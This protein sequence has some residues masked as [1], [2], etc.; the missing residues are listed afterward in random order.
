LNFIPEIYNEKLEL[1]SR[2]DFEGKPK[3]TMDDFFLFF[4]K[5]KFKMTKIIKRNCEQMLMSILKYAAEDT[6]IDLL[7]KF[8]G[9]GDDKV[10]RE[11][12][13]SYLTVLKNLPISFYKLFEEGFPEYLMTLDSCMEIFFSKF[14]NFLIHTESLDKLLRKSQISKAEKEIENLG[15]ESRKDI[16][17][18]MKYQ[19]KQN[20]SFQFLLNEFKNKTKNEESYIIIADQIMLANR[21]FDVNFFQIAELL[22]RNFSLVDDKIQLESFLDYFV[23]KFSFKVKV[24]DFMQVCIDSFSI[25]YTDLDKYLVKMWETADVRR[26][27]II[28]F[29]EFEAVLNVLLGNS[30][31]KWK[32]SD[33]FKLVFYFYLVFF[34]ILN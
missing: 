12:L 30:E 8:L 28:F 4:M 32:I 21:E 19:N 5:E 2:L 3:K 17:L 23:E 9:I 7:R 15:L 25:I 11:I 31:N 22:K 34:I 26:N 14:P 13:D 18:L 20:S 10:R 1:D 24:A 33:Y 29:K 27:G 16:F 6:R